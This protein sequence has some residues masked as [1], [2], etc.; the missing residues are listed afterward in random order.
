MT[1]DGNLALGGPFL[2]VADVVTPLATPK[3]RILVKLGAFESP[4][5]KRPKVRNGRSVRVVPLGGNW[6]Q[7]PESLCPQRC[8]TRLND[9]LLPPERSPP[10]EP[11]L[12][13]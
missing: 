5:F 4:G 12:E 11:E 2:C 9:M 7:S 6:G 1:E 8:S 10:E 13:H 3:E